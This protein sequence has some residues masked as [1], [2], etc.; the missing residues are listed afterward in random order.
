MNAT[1]VS[2]TAQSAGSSGLHRFTLLCMLFSVAGL[3]TGAM[4][5]SSGGTSFGLLHHIVAGTDAVV[6]MALGGWMA[7]KEPGKLGIALLGMAIATAALGSVPQNAFVQVLHACVAPIMF[8]CNWAAMVET[9]AKWKLPPELVEDH[10]WPSL[11]SL[12]RI[13]PV[14]VVI[15]I[16]LGAMFR[17]KVLGVLSHLFMAMILVLLIL[18]ICIFVM[19]QFP[20][21]KILR[22]AANQLMAIAFT[23]VFLGIAAFTVRSMS[24]TPESLVIG[25]TAVHAL[26][27]AMTLGAAVILG[28]QIRRNVYKKVED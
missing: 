24:T 21:H 2:S 25:F 27:G 20:T 7:A 5:T 19:Q 16:A 12:G 22:P 13:T 6:V 8:S 11:G 28:M 10:G 3:F 14:F 4:V 18:C 17:H 9:S 26:M 1:S 15:Q 23:Q